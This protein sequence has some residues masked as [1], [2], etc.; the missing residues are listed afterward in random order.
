MEPVSF[1]GGVRQISAV[2]SGVIPVKRL[3]G[4]LF[5]YTDFRWLTGWT[6]TAGC[7]FSVRDMISLIPSIGVQDFTSPLGQQLLKPNGQLGSGSRQLG[8]GS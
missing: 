8:A 1:S 4:Q 7:S 3:H 6:I 2:S 5:T